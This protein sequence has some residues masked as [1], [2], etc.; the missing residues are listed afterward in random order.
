MNDRKKGMMDIILF[1]RSAMKAMSSADRK[2][3]ESILEEYP[4]LSVKELVD[5]WVEGVYR[6][7]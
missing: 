4:D 5:Y 7:S 6:N 1:F 3:I 2:H